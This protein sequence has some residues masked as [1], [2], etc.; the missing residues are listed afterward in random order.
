MDPSEAIDVRDEVSSINSFELVR[1]DSYAEDSAET[2]TIA[3][4]ESSPTEEIALPLSDGSHLAPPSAK[5]SSGSDVPQPW[6]FYGRAVLLDSWWPE[7]AALAFSFGCLV[8]IVFTLR[9]YDGHPVSRLPLGLTL[10]TLLA[11][12]AACAKSS[13]IFAVA[14]TMSQCKWCWL[15]SEQG[16]RRHLH[17]LQVIDEA[18]R[19]P[20]GSFL[21]LLGRAVAS[22]L[23]LGAVITVLSLAFEPFIQQVVSYPVQRS[24][25]T[26]SAA[27]TTKSL[28]IDPSAL[29]GSMQGYVLAGILAAMYGSSFPDSTWSCSTGNCTWDS[30]W[31]V[32]WCS[33]CVPGEL[34]PQQCTLDYGKINQN[35]T[36]TC[37]FKF[38]LPGF[39]GKPLTATFG[40]IDGTQSLSYPLIWSL[41]VGSYNDTDPTEIIEYFNISGTEP[42]YFLNEMNPLLALGYAAPI[43]EP[44]SINTLIPSHIDAHV[45]VLTPCSRKYNLTVSKGIPVKEPVEEDYG[46]IFTNTGDN[47]LCWRP[48]D[49]NVTHVKYDSSL[50]PLDLER[51]IW[52]GI[53]VYWI[54]NMLHMFEGTYTTTWAESTWRLPVGGVGNSGNYILDNVLSGANYDPDR[55]MPNISAALTYLNLHGNT[56]AG[57]AYLDGFA[58]T[59]FTDKTFVV[60]RWAWLSLPFA[61]NVLGLAFLILTAVYTKRHQVPLWKTSAFALLYHG[62]D[63]QLLDDRRLYKKASDMENAA[64]TTCVRLA[65]SD[66]G[67]KRLLLCP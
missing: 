32:D 29:S 40:E 23:Y 34:L 28:G 65:P 16:R 38:S 53:D 6:F 52:C 19:G 62:L 37:D 5:L 59:A 13:L 7:A 1:L 66:G 15:R 51:R 39:S 12:L 54:E 63:E 41:S 10:N 44:T 61:L 33:K 45:C 49:Q 4:S 27:M 30:F 57:T 31:S 8:E 42:H 9:Y 64:S 25:A 43:Q 21:L 35:T 20:M 11:L 2:T 48:K 14:A 50:G 47:S 60:V 26:I 24:N 55:F 46:T 36:Q 67:R 17:H 58:G 56:G 18:S 3:V 22:L